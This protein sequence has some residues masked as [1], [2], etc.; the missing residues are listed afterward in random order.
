M[1]GFAELPFPFQPPR[2]SELHN[3]RDT[4][5][6]SWLHFAS[7]PR[8]GRLLALALASVVLIADRPNS[9]T[10]S[11]TLLALLLLNRFPWRLSA[12]WRAATGATLVASFVLFAGA[13]C[14]AYGRWGVFTDNGGYNLLIGHNRYTLE[15]LGRY[16]KGGLE[17]ILWDHADDLSLGGSLQDPARSDELRN[18]AVAYMI[19]NPGRTLQVS[20]MKFLRYFDVRLEN[21]A[22]YPLT[23]NLLYS[24]PYV[25]ALLLALGASLKP[26]GQQQQV[27]FLWVVV[28]A[29]AIPGI[30]TLPLIRMRMHTE[31][32]MLILSALGLSRLIGWREDVADE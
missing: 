3:L 25:A 31:S 13:R 14:L 22:H 11:A 4:T 18:R 19:A 16:D 12:G 17:A 23:K 1:L 29:Y 27:M 7:A 6:W 2:V 10:L 32:F 24:L 9:V 26:G 8:M 30:V 21:S 20:V 5:V 15:Y 28:L